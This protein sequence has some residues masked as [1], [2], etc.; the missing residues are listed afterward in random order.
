MIILVIISDVSKEGQKKGRLGLHH[1]LDQ[2]QLNSLKQSL[3][4]SSNFNARPGDVANDHVFR[5]T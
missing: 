2:M 3:S 4:F 5:S 1:C